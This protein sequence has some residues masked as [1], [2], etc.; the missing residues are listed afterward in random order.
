MEII[1]REEGEM[2][3]C[4]NVLIGEWFSWIISGAA[5]AATMGENKIKK[6]KK[7]NH[8]F[9][10]AFLNFRIIFDVDVNCKSSFG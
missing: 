9:F 8:L 3:T 7:E 4:A 5:I 6:K 1:Y 2:S 10:T